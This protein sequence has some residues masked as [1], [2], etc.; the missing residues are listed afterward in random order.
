MTK[1]KR[2]G[3]FLAIRCGDFVQIRFTNRLFKRTSKITNPNSSRV[4]SQVSFEGGRFI[5][6]F[7]YYRF[8]Q[9]TARG[10]ILDGEAVFLTKRDVKMIK[11]RLHGYWG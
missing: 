11:R 9:A 7:P 8:Y 6:G 1:R 3:R 5:I 4:L 2:K 10:C